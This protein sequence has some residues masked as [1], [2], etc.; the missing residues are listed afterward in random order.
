VVH[1]GDYRDDP[2]R[3]YLEAGSMDGSDIVITGDPDDLPDDIDEVLAEIQATHDVV[4]YPDRA[5]I[6]W[7]QPTPEGQF[8]IREPDEV[9]EDPYFFDNF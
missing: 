7:F 9:R 8:D 3:G 5:V 6:G 2:R 1:F 4:H